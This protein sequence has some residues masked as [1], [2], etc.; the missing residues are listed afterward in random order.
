MS[1]CSFPVNQPRVCSYLRKLVQDPPGTLLLEGGTEEDRKQA[2]LYWVMALNCPDHSG[3]C[4]QCTICQ[5][6]VNNGFRDMIYLQ[7]GH[8]VKVEE[9][10]SLRPLFFQKPRYFRKV[11]VFP[12]AQGLAPASASSLLKSLE[13]PGP[14]NCFVLTAPQRSMVLN[15][16]ASRSFILT[17]GRNEPPEEDPDF[18][19]WFEEFAGFI[20]TG[21]GLLSR[22]MKKNETDRNI[23]EKIIKACR[24]ELIASMMS[25]GSQG[26]FKALPSS[27]WH[28]A[29]LCLK[30]AEECLQYKTRPDL[31][32]EWLAVSLWKL[33]N[34]REQHVYR[35]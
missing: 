7:P 22:T 25:R 13:E 6:I 11:T 35:T 21:K 16:L 34:F 19:S 20:K 32:L 27:A 2:A 9:L 5:Q 24:Q 33:S 18:A 15:T 8:E 17:L 10:R 12:E 29:D 3:P 4:Q 14:G 23:A 1:A 30:K 31:V 26:L 28:R